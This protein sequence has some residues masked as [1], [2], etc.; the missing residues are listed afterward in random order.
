MG[1]VGGG[2][3]G[4]GGGFGSFCRDWIEIDKG[5]CGLVGTRRISAGSRSLCNG[6]LPLGRLTRGEPSN[7][8][9]SGFC[10]VHI[11]I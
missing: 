7:S 4:S 2:A 1:R 10:K 6:P 11:I 3:V 8:S 5:S 9:M